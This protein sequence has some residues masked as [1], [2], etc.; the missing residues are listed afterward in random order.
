MDPGNPPQSPRA[1]AKLRL[2]LKLKLK[3]RLE[4]KLKLDFGQKFGRLV[5]NSVVVR[6]FR[7]FCG[8]SAIRSGIR[9]SVVPTR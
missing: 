8:Q 1:G 3:L 5:R 2:R 9:S 6:D 4:L 7:E